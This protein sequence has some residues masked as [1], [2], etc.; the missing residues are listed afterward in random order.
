MLLQ[1]EIY[2][3]IATDTSF[4]YCDI[5]VLLNIDCVRMKKKRYT[6]N[7][8]WMPIGLWGVEALTFSRKLAHRWRWD[9]QSYEPAALYSQEDSWHSFMLKAVD[10]RAIVRLKGLSQ[11]GN[12]VTS[13]RIGPVTFR[14][15]AYSPINHATWCHFHEWDCRVLPISFVLLPCFSDND[16]HVICRQVNDLST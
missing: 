14:L 16:G 12:P 2:T 7:R 8:Q 4:Y 1:K 11:L 10:P 9:F 15:V 5:R 6:W 13:S 3:L